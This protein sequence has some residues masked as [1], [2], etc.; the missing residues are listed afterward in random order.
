[1][2]KISFG[3]KSELGHLV[4]ERSGVAQ[5]QRRMIPSSPKPLSN[6]SSSPSFRQSQLGWTFDILRHVDLWTCFYGGVGT[7]A[8]PSS[9][10]AP[11]CYSFKFCRQ[12]KK[13]VTQQQQQ[14]E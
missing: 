14:H 2:L 12:K 11:G 1:M 13:K 10:K 6:A 3:Q 5:N 7:G 4:P 9:K 8:F